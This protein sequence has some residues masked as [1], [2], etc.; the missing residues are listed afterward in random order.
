MYEKINEMLEFCT[1][2]AQIMYFPPQILE[3]KFGQILCL[4]S[5]VQICQIPPS[6]ALSPVSS[7]YVSTYLLQP[8][9]L[10]IMFV[11]FDAMRLKLLQTLLS[12][13]VLI[14]LSGPCLFCPAVHQV[15]LSVSNCRDE[16]GW[17]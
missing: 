2:I 17:Y 1:I 6:S 16:C 5:I 11:S 8:S 13:G 10:V 12:A 4:L 9:S 3:K 14:Q 15:S 7:A